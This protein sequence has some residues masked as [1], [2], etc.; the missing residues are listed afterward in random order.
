MS[1]PGEYIIEFTAVGNTVKV[2][3]IDPITLREATIVGPTSAS[4]VQLSE[5][6]VRKLLYVLGK[7]QES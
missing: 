5:L 1:R 7:K 2:T 3:A 4:N 6:A